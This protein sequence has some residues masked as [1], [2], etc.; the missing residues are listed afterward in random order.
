MKTDK[1]STPKDYI[2]PN[3]N[4]ISLFDTDILVE[5]A[6]NRLDLNKVALYEL[7]NRGLDKDGKW[8]GFNKD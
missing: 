4:V 1:T 5:V 6:N 2:D 3:K 7:K 8:V